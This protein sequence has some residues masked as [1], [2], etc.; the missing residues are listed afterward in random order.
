MEVRQA[1]TDRLTRPLWVLVAMLVKEGLEENR[2]LV[3]K[4]VSVV[5]PVLVALL[6]RVVSA[7]MPVLVVKE[8]VR[9]P[10]VQVRLEEQAETL[11]LVAMAELEALRDS[12]E[13]EALQ[14]SAA[15]EVLVAKLGLVALEVLRDLVALVAPAVLLD[16]AAKVV[17]RWHLL[18]LR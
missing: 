11:G 9:P 6:G 3:V 4:A 14:D 7:E 10:A 16:L 5:R 2:R 17:L 13:L 18:R 15:P 8:A 12:V 1:L